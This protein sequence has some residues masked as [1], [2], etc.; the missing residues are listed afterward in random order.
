[1][2]NHI[3]E[4]EGVEEGGGEEEDEIHTNLVI[5]SQFEESAIP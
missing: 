1:M 2:E 4:I 3:E 5:E